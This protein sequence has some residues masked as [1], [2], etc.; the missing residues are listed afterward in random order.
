MYLLI[1]QSA[2]WA[3]MFL[4][5]MFNV[6]IH[7]IS[8][9]SNSESFPENYS[10]RSST[11]QGEEIQSSL[12]HENLSI[13][14]ATTKPAPLPLILEREN[15][16]FIPARTITFQ[17]ELGSTACTN[18]SLASRIKK[19]VSCPSAISHCEKRPLKPTHCIKQCWSPFMRPPNMHKQR[20][21]PAN[22]P[23]R[24]GSILIVQ[25]E[26]S[27]RD[28]AEGGEWSNVRGEADTQNP[29]WSININAINVSERRKGWIGCVIGHRKIYTPLFRGNTR[30]PPVTSWPKYIGEILIQWGIDVSSIG[31]S[32]G[33]CLS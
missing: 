10:R 25:R 7:S 15:E 18:V 17:N 3:I 24:A 26:R 5:N 4:R 27:E 29:Y 23:L 33:N 1:Y 9:N 8:I 19:C 22:M 30:H 2:H 31:F 14:P 20:R 6:I 12:I 13:S 28:R 16:Y 21:V 32:S 11:V